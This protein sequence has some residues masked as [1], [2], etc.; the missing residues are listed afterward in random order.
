[1]AF[2]KNPAHLG[3]VNAFG[4][5]ARQQAAFAS[6]RRKNTGGGSKLIFRNQFQPSLYI[7]DTIRIVPGAY[8]QQFLDDNGNLIEGNF[9]FW[10]YVEHFHGVLKKSAFCS[11]GPF[12]WQ[13]GQAA[14][15]YGCDIYWEDWRT[16]KDTGNK[17]SP[18]RLSMRDM[19][20]YTIVDQGLFHKVEDTDQ[21]G[22]VKVN[23][24]TQQPY[25]SWVKC[26]GQQCQN[27]ALG[28]ETKQG[29]V[30]PWPMG[31]RHFGTINA[32]ADQIGMGCMT[33]GSRVSINTLLWHCGNPECGETMIDMKSTNLNM[34]QL[35][36]RTNEPQTCPR[37]Q[38][39]LFMQ[40]IY[41]CTVC[42]PKG[43]VAQRA[44]IFDVDM[45][46]RR[47][48][49]PDESGTQLMIVGTSDP[50]VINP[51]FNDIAKPL[52]LN[53]MY[54]PTDLNLQ[55]QLFR[56]QVQPQQ[57][58]PPQ[59]GVDPQGAPGQPPPG[60]QQY[61][62]PAQQA[63]QQQYQQPGQQQQYQQ[64]GQQQGFDFPPQG[65]QPPQQ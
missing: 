7:P 2:G 1:M 5:S 17:N 57:A 53:E 9:P 47:Q 44:S 54:S 55:A 34:E 27:C 26:D 33:C 3:N 40:D 16:R 52:K 18:K 64:P 28:K 60:T 51:M 59:Q 19:Y 20:A 25:M 31:K 29:H 43:V 11:A 37:C 4:G 46:V 41:E 48:K 61:Q 39:N 38:Q 45:Q 22:R 65:G 63:P 13:K 35:Y 21:Q 49:S 62:Q 15:C 6:R 56:I 58:P 12:R 14:P 8:F 24:S 50:S 36:E 10:S 30:Q 42:T 32:Y 23:P